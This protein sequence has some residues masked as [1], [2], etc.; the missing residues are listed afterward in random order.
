ML[1]DRI[2]EFPDDILVNIL[3]LLTMK[4]AVRTSILSHRWKNLWKLITRRLDFDDWNVLQGID[5]CNLESWR[6]IS[7]KFDYNDKYDRMFVFR[8]IANLR[9]F[10]LLR[11]KRSKYMRWV[12]RILASHKGNS[13]ETFRVHFDLDLPFKPDIDRWINFAIDKRVQRLELD[14][15]RLGRDT[16]DCYPFP[17]KIFSNPNIG[18]LKALSLN[19]V[20]V[21]KEVLDSLLQK[22]PTLE[23][24]HVSNS[25]CLVG[26]VSF[27][28]SQKLKHLEIVQCPKLK[29]LQIS[30]TNLRSLTFVGPKTTRLIVEN[31]PNLTSVSFGGHYCHHTI[32]AFPK[33][34]PTSQFR[35]RLQMLSLD[36]I[37]EVSSNK[38]LF[39][40]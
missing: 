25:E 12:Q 7:R 36:I 40:F 26:L 4:E 31:N 39:S 17:V 5:R 32:R 29:Y 15:E 13:I 28:A 16:K 24:L 6:C 35:S 34:L 23:F 1:V 37:E 20:D 21:N 33:M 3:S 19:Y 10:A 11:L 18:L 9:E 30:A 38:F 2:S 22:C 27:G 8:G 14:L